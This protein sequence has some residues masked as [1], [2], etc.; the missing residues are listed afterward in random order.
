M[1]RALIYGAATRV[2]ILISRCRSLALAVDGQVE[3]CP[4]SRTTITTEEEADRPDLPT[5][6]ARLAPNC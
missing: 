2:P 4:I 6:S 3:Q 1:E 5:F